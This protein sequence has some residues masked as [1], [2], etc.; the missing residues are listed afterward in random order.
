VP[1]KDKLALH[2]FT[3][4][5]SFKHKVISNQTRHISYLTL[6]SLKTILITTTFYKKT[7]TMLKQFKSPHSVQQ[8]N[9]TMKAPVS[10]Q[11][12]SE[13][14]VLSIQHENTSIQKCKMMLTAC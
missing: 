12:F 5:L 4:E 6:Y 2:H 9:Q 3:S 11:H 1:C 8:H 14:P 10:V 13:C 7:L